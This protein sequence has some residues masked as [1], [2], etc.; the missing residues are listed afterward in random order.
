VIRIVGFDS[1]VWSRLNPGF[2]G[3]RASGIRM[4]IVSPLRG[5][6]RQ[7]Q[8][9][10]FRLRGLSVQN[11]HRSSVGH[12]ARIGWCSRQRDACVSP[13][14]IVLG[15][16]AVAKQGYREPTDDPLEIEGRCRVRS[17]PAHDEG[18]GW[19]ARDEESSQPRYWTFSAR[20]PGVSRRSQQPPGVPEPAS[21]G[22]IH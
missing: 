18:R 17:Q 10:P 20:Y 12:P 22:P 8:S 15:V 1:V 6:M 11:V 16:R 7:G 9:R 19:R 21:T 13:C 14:P 4:A 5:R 3:T 2:Q